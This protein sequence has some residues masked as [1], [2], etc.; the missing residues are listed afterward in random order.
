MYPFCP[1]IALIHTLN[2]GQ[3]GI[4]PGIEKHTLSHVFVYGD[5]LRW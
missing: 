5:G 3:H 2:T 4:L 1:K